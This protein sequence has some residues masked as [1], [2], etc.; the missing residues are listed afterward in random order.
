M[1]IE[2]KIKHKVGRRKFL[3]VAGATTTPFFGFPNISVAKTY[4]RVHWSW[5]GASDAAVWKSCIDDFN[6]AHDCKGVQIKMGSIV[7][8]QYDTKLLASA[9]SG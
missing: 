4:E 2:K 1:K 9:A 8:D 7:N 5:L 6:A 3:K